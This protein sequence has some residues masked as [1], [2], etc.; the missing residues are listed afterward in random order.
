[1]PI[2]VAGEVDFLR[3]QAKVLHSCS[4]ELAQEVAV[5]LPGPFNEV[6]GVIEKMIFRRMAEQKDEDAHKHWC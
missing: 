2:L 6:M 4:L 1:M 3:A 5:H